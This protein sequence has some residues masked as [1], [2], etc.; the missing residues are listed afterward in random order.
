MKANGKIAA[1][2]VAERRL[3]RELRESRRDYKI[4][5]ARLL[6]AEERTRAANAQIGLLFAQR[7]DQVRSNDIL[8]SCLAV[9]MSALRAR[10]VGDD[11]RIAAAE[12]IEWRRS[13]GLASDMV[14]GVQPEEAKQ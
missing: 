5:V 9:A 13:R 1:A 12:G 10:D 6:G 7:S 2:V 14:N 8:Y 4:A 3:R 11:V